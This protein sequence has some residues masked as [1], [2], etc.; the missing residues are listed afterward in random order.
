MTPSTAASGADAR[1]ATRQ[2]TRARTVGD[3]HNGGV[4]PPV[5]GFPIPW[6]VRNAGLAILLNRNLESPISVHGSRCIAIPDPLPHIKP[7]EIPRSAEGFDVLFICSSRCADL[8][9]AEEILDLTTRTDCMVRGACEAVSAA[10]RACFA[11][12]SRRARTS[13]KAYCSRT[14]QPRTWPT[15]CSKTSARRLVSGWK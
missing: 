2:T 1:L 11:T 15:D 14:K 3:F 8:A 4:F 12:T 13:Q 5:G 7:V 6:I 9:A 10:C